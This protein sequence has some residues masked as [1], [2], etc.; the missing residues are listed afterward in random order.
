MQEETRKNLEYVQRVLTDVRKYMDAASV[1]NYDQ[2]TICPPKGMEEQG[3]VMAF[4]ENQAFRLK[5]DPAFLEAAEKLY[6][7]REELDEFDRVMAESLHREYQNTKNITPEKQEQV[8]KAQNRAFVRWLEAK[9]KSDYSLYRDNLKEVRDLSV[10]CAALRENALPDSY[11]NMLEDYG[12]GIHMKEIDGWFSRVKERLIPLLRKIQASPVKIRRD[13][14]SRPVTDEQ[15]RQMAD[16][17]MQVIGYDLTRGA[18]ALTEH[19][20]TSSL[21]RDNVRI[22]THFHPDAFASSMYSVI[23]EGGHALFD[24]LQPRE[25]YDH[26]IEDEKS[27]GMHESV[28]RFYENRIG[29]SREFVHL[30]YDRTREIFPQ[31]MHDVSEEELYQ[32]LNIVEPSYIRTEADEFTYSFHII[33]RYE[34]EKALMQGTVTMEELPEVWNSKYEEYLGIRPRNDRE[35]IL[36][37]VH[38]TF[39]FGYFPCYALGNMYNA[40]YYNR[41]KKEMDL[42]SLV[43]KG[44]FAAINSWMA[45]NVFK[46]ADRLSPADWIRDITG[47]D[48]TPDDFLDYLEEKYS[49]IYQL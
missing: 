31:V 14:L 32:A 39:G 5:K 24:Q 29:R 35:G 19:P 25:N 47:R 15:Q 23:H 49:E 28:S 20:F 18:L 38:W 36:Q 41:M 46:K 13:F 4:L 17:L 27:M 22:T 33:I 44:D 11:D 26:F 45:E 12:R 48:F 30:I 42:P 7:N 16:Y 21:G 3:E 8:A 2:E 37:D 1:L 10:E 9:E 40:M 43:A 6:L 34:I